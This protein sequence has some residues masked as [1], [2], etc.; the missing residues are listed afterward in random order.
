ML[1]FKMD[2]DCLNDLVL[3]PNEKK[4]KRKKLSTSGFFCSS[5]PQSENERKRND[6]LSTH[7]RTKKK[8]AVEH[9]C[10]GDTN[11]NGLQRLGKKTGEIKG[12][13]ETL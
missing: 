13:I 5:E 3:I 9:E 11:L 7:K 8:K 1:L 12:K 4:K 10:D 6:G 2:V